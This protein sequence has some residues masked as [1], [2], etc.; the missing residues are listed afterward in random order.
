MEFKQIIIVLNSL[1]FNNRTAPQYNLSELIVRLDI[2]KAISVSSPSK[3][4]I[5]L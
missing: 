1:R 4:Q 5:L 3:H 2:A